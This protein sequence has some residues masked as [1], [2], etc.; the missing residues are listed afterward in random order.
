MVITVG[1]IAAAGV[2]LRRV[3]SRDSGGDAAGPP[4]VTGAAASAE[5]GAEIA[6]DAERA[7]AYIA[8]AGLGFNEQLERLCEVGIVLLIAA[9]RGRRGRR[10]AAGGADVR[11]GRGVRRAARGVGDA[12]DEVVRERRTR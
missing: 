3:E 1:L 6:T 11:D 7:P 12:A 5:G 2:L 4:D 8:K 10:R 9:A